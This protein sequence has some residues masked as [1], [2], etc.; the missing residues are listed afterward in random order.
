MRVAERFAENYYSH[1]TN[2]EEKQKVEKEVAYLWIVSNRRADDISW[3][4]HIRV[5]IKYQ[6]H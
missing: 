6:N 4:F 3:S 5:H 2:V 1:A